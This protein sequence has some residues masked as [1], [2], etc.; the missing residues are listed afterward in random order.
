MPKYTATMTCSVGIYGRDYRLVE[1]REIDL[2][3]RGLAE[4]VRPRGILVAAEDEAR[5]GEHAPPPDD[6]PAET[7]VP[8]EDV[9]EPNPKQ[10]D[11][12]QNKERT[13]ETPPAP[14][15]EP[16]PTP[17]LDPMPDP[18]PRP[19]EPVRR[20]HFLS[21]RNVPLRGKGK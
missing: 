11:G 10:R 9:A 19:D 6:K 4:I 12:Y 14:E 13:V 16:V 18:E 2:P 8:G 20:E 5:P 1:G 21:S 15:P 3:Y 7:V 17:A